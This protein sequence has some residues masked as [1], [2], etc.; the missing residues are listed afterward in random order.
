MKLIE[1][2]DILNVN[3]EVIYYNNQNNRWIAQFEYAEVKDSKGSCVLKSEYGN[4]CSPE[5][6]IEDYVNQIKGKILVFN[7]MSETKRREYLVPDSLEY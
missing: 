7:A 5:I 1:Y 3:L 6:A 4:G 2:A